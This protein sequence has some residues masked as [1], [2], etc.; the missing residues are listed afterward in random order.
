MK[1]WLEYRPTAEIE[2]K[3]PDGSTV[4]ISKLP[5]QKLSEF[6]EENPQL[7]VFEG[8]SSFMSSNK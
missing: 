1:T 8:L 6:F 3:C 5:L 4:K 2:L 7:S